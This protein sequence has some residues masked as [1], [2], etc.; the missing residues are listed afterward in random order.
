MG[1]WNSL[2]MLGELGDRQQDADQAKDRQRHQ[3]HHQDW[4][5]ITSSA[6]DILPPLIGLP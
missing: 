5:T 3:T 4:H 2:V 1:R 6:L